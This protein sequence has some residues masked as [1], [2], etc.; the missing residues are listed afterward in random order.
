MQRLIVA[1]SSVLLSRQESAGG[2]GPVTTDRFVADQESQII[3]MPP[4][5][6]A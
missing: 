3:I 4:S 2:N 6:E 5:K 1:V